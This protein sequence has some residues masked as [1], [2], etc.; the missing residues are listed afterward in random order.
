MHKV[1]LDKMTLIIIIIFINESKDIVLLFTFCGK[2]LEVSF[3]PLPD[4]V[5]CGEFKFGLKR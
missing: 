4:Q 5:S 3:S 1:I 2:S